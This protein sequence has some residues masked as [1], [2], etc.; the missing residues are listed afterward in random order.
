M[1][2]N[3]RFFSN[4]QVGVKSSDKKNNGLPS[5]LSTKMSVILREGVKR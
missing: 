2:K 3:K 5:M 4:Q 1:Q